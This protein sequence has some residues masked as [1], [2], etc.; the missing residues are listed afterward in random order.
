MMTLIFCYDIF[1]YLV[2]L[3]FFKSNI[4]VASIIV[5]KYYISKFINSLKIYLTINLNN[6][7]FLNNTFLYFDLGNN[8]S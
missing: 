3:I 5:E 7:T 2:S 8:R 1:R 6:N 4:F